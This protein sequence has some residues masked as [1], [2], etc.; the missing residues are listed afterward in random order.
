MGLE[1]N[2]CVRVRACMAASVMS[3]PSKKETSSLA[4]TVGSL[5]LA[6]PT[7]A[8]MVPLALRKRQN[9]TIHNRIITLYICTHIVRTQFVPGGPLT[10][11]LC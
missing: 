6:D 3:L 4:G 1:I 9:Q 10:A 11:A 5:A 2:L 8:L 7:M